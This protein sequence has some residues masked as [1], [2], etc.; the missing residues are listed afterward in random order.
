[1][2]W[3]VI[4]ALNLVG[5]FLVPSGIYAAPY[6]TGRAVRIFWDDVT[7]KFRVHVYNSLGADLGE[8]LTGPSFTIDSRDVGNIQLITKFYKYC[9]GTT[10]REFHPENKNR[11]FFG[12]GFRPNGTY[13]A[14]VQQGQPLLLVFP[15][16]EQRTTENHY[17]CDTY[18][19]DID[20]DFAATVITPDSGTSDGSI[21]V[22]ATSSADVRFSRDPNATYAASAGTSNTYT[23]T[24]LASG[25][26][27]I[28]AVDAQGCRAS[29]VVFVPSTAVPYAVRWRAE[30]RDLEGNF[31]RFDIEEKGYAGSVVEVKTVGDNPVNPVWKGQ[32]ES[33]IFTP[34]LPSEVNVSLIS[35]TDFQFVDLFTQD[36]RK[37]RGKLY[38]ERTNIDRYP[39]LPPSL[40]V[41]TDFTGSNDATADSTQFYAGEI[42]TLKTLVAYQPL[43]VLN[44]NSVSFDVDVTSFDLTTDNVTFA[45]YNNDTLVSTPV[46]LNTGLSQNV[47]LTASA[48]ANR[49]RITVEVAGTEGVISIQPQD[50]NVVLTSFSTTETTLQ[51]VG[52]SIPMLYSEPYYMDYNYPVSVTF[53]DQLADLSIKPFTDDSGNEI[54]GSISVL[55]A[56]SFIV[57]KTDLT[58]NIIESVNLFE[59]TMDQ[60]AEDSAIQQLYFDSII[61]LG[62]NCEETLQSLLTNLG[63]RMYQDEAAWKIELIEERGNSYTWREFTVNGVYVTNG[64]TY[65]VSQ[66]KKATEAQRSVLRDRT[67]NI[68]IMPSYGEIIFEISTLFNNNLLTQGTFEYSELINNQIRGW[69]FDL[70]N[71]AG[72]SYGLE[73]LEEER[74]GSKTALFVDFSNTDGDKNIVITA[75]EFDLD[76]VSGANLK[77]KFDVLFRPYFKD[78][79]QYIDISLKIGDDYAIPTVTDMPNSLIDGEYQRF[80]MDTV[81][82]WKTIE[83]PIVTTGRF[84]NSPVEG[85]VT[86]KIRASNS[87]TVNYASITALR[88]QATVTNFTLKFN[89]KRARVQDGDILRL[90][91]LQRGSDADAA[92]DIIRPNDYATTTNEWVWKLDKSFDLPSEEYLLAGLLIDNVKLFIETPDQPDIITVTRQINTDI[93]QTFTLPLNHSDLLVSEQT[94][95][96]DTLNAKRLT[97]SWFRLSNGTPTQLWK[98]KYVD[99]ASPVIDILLSIYQGQIS[100]PTYKLSGSLYSDVWPTMANSFYEARLQKYFLANYLSIMDKGSSFDAELIELRTSANGSPPGDDQ[101]EFT[102]EHATDFNA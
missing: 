25:N 52:Y 93:K 53:T 69:T 79:W 89:Q 35:E 60:A 16:G 41:S 97:K 91:T 31:S 40:W 59:T 7:L 98:R 102:T 96:S 94:P 54:S 6:S 90:Y 68:T 15:Y 86:L 87:L 23:F 17:S 2:K 55:D 75:E 71:G 64:T 84:I 47:L 38:K 27:T 44:G 24:A 99:E 88:A 56:I 50:I 19:C 58:I 82:E 80:Y 77:L 78:I 37:F 32:A 65:P 70:N 63:A 29:L 61:Y 83:A 74:N 13:D 26:Y 14:R 81:L 42:G 34:V 100:V 1:M 72:I 49:L 76:L 66:I 48:E 8:Q 92:P 57:R 5:Q 85:P 18:V 12:Q 51:W 28:Y 9:D 46:T 73:E 3:I 95:T 4:M 36:E 10:L 21:I 43:R 39:F 20:F 62:K 101:F 33:N 22:T 11:T 30:H 67:G 45:L